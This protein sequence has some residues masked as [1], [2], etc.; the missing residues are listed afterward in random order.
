MNQQQRNEL[1]KELKGADLNI[2]SAVPSEAASKREV[3]AK[4]KQ[5][6]DRSKASVVQVLLV[7]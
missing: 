6:L 5:A 2:Y 1:M 4:L 7:E 3:I